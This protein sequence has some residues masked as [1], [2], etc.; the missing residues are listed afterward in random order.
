MDM[1]NLF[2][3]LQSIDKDLINS[4]F[5]SAGGFFALNHCRVLFEHKETRGVSMV[6]AAFFASWGF[7][8]LVYYTALTQPLSFYGAIFL[9]SA[10]TVYL[11]MMV[12]YSHVAETNS[13]LMTHE[14]IY[15]APER[16]GLGENH[17]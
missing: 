4:G 14:E 17:E 7:W 11:G 15:L 3:F 16:V 10:N 13:W 2:E 1:N 9:S 5:E 6:S 8:N 12:Y